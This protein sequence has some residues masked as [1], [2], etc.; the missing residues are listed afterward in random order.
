MFFG[1]VGV[2]N[3]DN[4]ESEKIGFIPYVI[5]YNLLTKTEVG[6]YKLYD[7]NYIIQAMDGA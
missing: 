4:S 1:L 3:L 5:L 6:P 2:N 7:T